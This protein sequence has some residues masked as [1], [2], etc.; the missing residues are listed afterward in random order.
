M[1]GS[2][3]SVIILN[4]QRSK[5]SEPD[6]NNPNAADQLEPELIWTFSLEDAST[7]KNGDDDDSW[8]PSG[9]FEVFHPSEHDVHRT[10][11]ERSIMSNKKLCF[12]GCCFCA[13]LI[14]F[15]AALSL[16]T[17][18]VVVIKKWGENC[19][20]ESAQ[21]GSNCIYNNLDLDL[22]INSSVTT[23]IQHCTILGKTYESCPIPKETYALNE[24]LS[25]ERITSQV[26]Y[27]SQCAMEDRWSIEQDKLWIAHPVGP[28]VIHR[29][30]IPPLVATVQQAQM[31]VWL[32]LCGRDFVEQPV[33]IDFT[34]NSLDEIVIEA[35]IRVS[36][37][38]AK[39]ETK[40]LV[41]SWIDFDFPVSAS[42][43]TSLELIA[44]ITATDFAL[45]NPSDNKLTAVKV[46]TI[47]VS[48]NITDIGDIKDDIFT[49][50]GECSGEFN[51]CPY[52]EEWLYD[53]ISVDF[54]ELVWEWID[55]KFTEFVPEI[56]EA[57]KIAAYYEID[58]VA[59]NWLCLAVECDGM[60]VSDFI[61][62]I[63][64]LFWIQVGIL[65]IVGTTICYFSIIFRRECAKRCEL[66][67]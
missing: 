60:T 41:D 35:V 7:A 15:L 29:I 10:S 22:S 34:M 56:E 52:V 66:R 8:K 23:Q 36:F 27:S 14:Y 30:D 3:Q 25:L 57:I 37:L 40:V 59:F 51:V 50:D 63:V 42:A 12:T 19:E 44:R 17:I 2:S 61:E 47:S 13:M 21:M 46:N 16:L 55:T 43:S 45:E 9:N 5:Y 32:P 53:T 65:C 24:L 48:L 26:G 54:E 62:T 31:L 67:M 49:F 6:S 11:P 28:D 64:V 39:I 38:K 33:L 58:S 1:L 20:N 18:S 4:G